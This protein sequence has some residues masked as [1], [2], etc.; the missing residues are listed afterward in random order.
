MS[1]SPPQ[2]GNTQKEAISPAER[3]AVTLRFLATGKMW[4]ILEIEVSKHISKSIYSR[5]NIPLYL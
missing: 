3:L 4:I 2:N 5:I 1:N